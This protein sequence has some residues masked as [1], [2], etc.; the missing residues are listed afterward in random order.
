[1][2]AEIKTSTVR[3]PNGEDI[4]FRYYDGK[5]N[6]LLLLHG[7]M[8]S[9]RFFQPFFPYLE[10]CRIIAPDMRGYGN[11]S[12]NKSFNSLLELA[13]D[14]AALC[15]ELCLGQICVAGW[16]TGGGVALELA[17]LRPDIVKGVVLIDGISH[18]GFP[19]PPKD[20]KGKP[21][22]GAYY[23]T[24]EELVGD[25][26]QVGLI[27]EAIAN[28]DEGALRRIFDKGI[29][30]VKRPDDEEYAAYIHEICKQRCNDD[31]YW[32]LASFN[33]SDE[34]TGINN[35]NRHIEMVRVPVLAFHGDKD[36]ICEPWQ[37]EDN[38]KA[39]G[40]LMELVILENCGHAAFTDYPEEIGRRILA[41]MD[42]TIAGGTGSPRPGSRFCNTAAC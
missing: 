4:F 9:S 21:I 18:R 34:F 20:D 42:M 6:T 13:E 24:R 40:N 36:Y 11:S 39:L 10:R 5:P 1:M 26:R 30:V 38:K 17:A 35:G 16:S 31:A 22:P 14:I 23:K 29:Y 2:I 15:D 37:A 33:M 41:F 12:Y 7:N 32:A 25:T 3:L 19:V 27:R 8:A 28:C